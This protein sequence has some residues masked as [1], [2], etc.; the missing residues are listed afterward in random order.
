MNI[1]MVGHSGA[2]K[3]SFM[4]G[5]YKYLG[6]SA[7][8]YGISAKKEHQKKQLGGMADALSQGKYP[9]GTDVQS[10]YEFSFTVNGEDLIPFNWID[11]RGGILL[12][13]SPDD[14]DMDK[15]MAAI[16]K[17]DALVVF[18]DGQK[19]S[20]VGSRWNMEYDILISCIENSLTVN[21]QSW[22]PISFVITKCDLVPDNASFHGLGRFENL[23]SQ[24][25]QS[26]T[27]G[28]MLIQCSIT[29]ESFYSPFLV[30]AYSVYGGTPIYINRTIK[31]INSAQRRAEEHRPT[32]LLG[33]LF[34]GVEMVLSG[35]AEI[36][37]SGWQ[38]E[39]EKTWAAEADANKMQLKLEELHNRAEELKG[40]LE[41]WQEDNLIQCM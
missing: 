2:G 13:D 5:L 34:G 31:A 40:K 3:T 38:T 22:F 23:L 24:I 19:L 8:G 35:A 14:S 37:D 25:S 26:K 9:A 28:A 29:S 36:F 1:L 32:S 21:H 7:D 27:V 18:L 20:Q 10:Q 4:A 11:Y 17:A 39:Y 6:E 33:K 30:L 12:S 41:K 15:F 16:Q